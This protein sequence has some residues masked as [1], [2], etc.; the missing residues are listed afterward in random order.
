MQPH[1]DTENIVSEL[2]RTLVAVI[3]EK[4]EFMKGHSERVASICVHFSIKLELQKKEIEQVYLAG[5]L[6]L[7]L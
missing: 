3:E 2:V 7:T 5:I 1:K 6:P 4:D